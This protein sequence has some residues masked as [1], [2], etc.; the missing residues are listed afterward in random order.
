MIAAYEAI[1]EIDNR[2]KPLGLEKHEPPKFR[3]RRFLSLGENTTCNDQYGNVAEFWNPTEI[4]QHVETREPIRKA[5]IEHG[6]YDRRRS[7]QLDSAIDRF[8]LDARI[9]R[10]SQKSTRGV[11][12]KRLIVQDENGGCVRRVGI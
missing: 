7:Q 8:C 12:D 11:P 6:C 9:P 5:H 2:R 1:E 10:T 3:D 4:F